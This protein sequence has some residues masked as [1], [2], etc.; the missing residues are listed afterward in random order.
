MSWPP[1]W[2]RYLLGRLLRVSSAL[3]LSLAL[4]LI[5]L[6]FGLQANMLLREVGWLH[7]PGHYLLVLSKRAP[8]LLSVTVALSGVFVGYQLV[9][10][11]EWVALLSSGI[12]VRKTGRPFLLFAGVCSLLL[13]ANAQW[14]QPKAVDQ[15]DALE[16]PK[17]LYTTTLRD[18]SRLICRQASQGTL[19]DVWWISED[20]L[21]HA[22]R[23]LLPSREVEHGQ[24]W[25]FQKQGWSRHDEALTAFMQETPS[26]VR[27][28]SA[29]Y[30]EAQKLSRLWALTM[31]KPHPKMATLAILRV[32]FS[33][34]PLFVIAWILPM[35]LRYQRSPQVLQPAVIALAGVL[36][37]MTIWESTGLLTSLDLLS[38]W[39]GLGAPALLLGGLCFLRWARWK[40]D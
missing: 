25:R 31:E 13:L 38:I 27:W 22:T 10:Q 20:R 34:L 23:V 18:G 40:T 39:W 24:G 36:L 4:L 37:S 16:G 33:L 14:L 17:S 2:E 1:L 32:L 19:E 7:L 29:S 28:Q 15:L 9:K 5:L 21:A 30:A 35:V 26:K 6:D 8:L 3:F 12:S 11:H